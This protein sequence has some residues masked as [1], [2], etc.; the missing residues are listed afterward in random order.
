[1]VDR[2]VNA[3]V[4]QVVWIAC[5][6]GGGAGIWW[7]GPIAVLG[8]CLWQVSVSRFRQSDVSMLLVAAPLGMAVESL[9]IAAGLLRYPSPG[10][11]GPRLAPIWII[12]L[13]VGFALTLNHSLAW[14][15]GKP[16]LA[17]LVGGLAGPL[18]YWIGAST[19]HAAQF[20]VP[21]PIVLGA[22]AMVWAVATPSLAWLADRFDDRRADETTDIGLLDDRRSLPPAI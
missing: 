19:W 4:F 9:L 13:W 17:M 7:L 12:A 18:S 10:P 1:M 22:L 14:L 8:F 2:I 6:G 20:T 5:V 16:V 15:K 21:T 11:W 3:V